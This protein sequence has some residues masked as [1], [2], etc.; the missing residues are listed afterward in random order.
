[1]QTE[2]PAPLLENVNDTDTPQVT[3]NLV[4]KFRKG[5]QR[6]L[7]QLVVAATIL[8]AFLIFVL[9]SKPGDNSVPKIENG[10]DPIGTP[11]T[12]GSSDAKAVVHIFSDFQCL[13]C[14]KFS[15]VSEKYL[16]ED[17]VLKGDVRLVFHPIARLGEESR[18][19]AEAAYCASD[20]RY[21]W[22]YKDIL[23]TYQSGVN[24]GSF[25]QAKLEE[26]AA[27]ISGLNLPTFKTCLESGQH[28]ADIN[29]GPDPTSYDNPNDVLTLRVNARLLTSQYDYAELQNLI[30][31]V[32]KHN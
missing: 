32:I 17:Y 29:P 22:Q 2:S 14:G 26:Y 18:W 10:L 5:S 25:S 27:K 24:Q 31:E 30:E 21:F 15:A 8:A 12:L 7:V 28:L 23:F 3:K 20:Q 19:A 13:A 6:R 11:L 1:M 4:R 9:V 16:I